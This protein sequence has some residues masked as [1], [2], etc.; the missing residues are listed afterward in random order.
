[1]R[2]ATEYVYVA[3][4]MRRIIVVAVLLFGAL[5]A[6]WLAVVVLRVIPLEFY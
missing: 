2:A 1:M 6:L 4:D 5:V 3:Q